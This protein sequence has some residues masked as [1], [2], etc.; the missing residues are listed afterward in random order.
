MLRSRRISPDAGRS[1]GARDVCRRLEPSKVE[2]LIQGYFDGVLSTNW[3]A[4]FRLTKAPFRGTHADT[5]YPDG[6]LDH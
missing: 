2:E 5:A 4:D 1:V 6:H 3:S